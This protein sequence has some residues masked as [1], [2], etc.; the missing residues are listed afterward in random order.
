M[1]DLGFNEKIK[2]VT[3]MSP[4]FNLIPFET[5]IRL[6]YVSYNDTAKCSMVSVSILKRGAPANTLRNYNVA[7]W[8]YLG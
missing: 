3:R 6:V 8:L 2:E 4:V 1:G 7:Y 5:F